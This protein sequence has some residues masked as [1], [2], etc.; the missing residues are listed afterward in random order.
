MLRHWKMFCV[1]L[2]LLPAGWVAYQLAPIRTPIVVSNETTHLTEP[3]AE[4]GLPDYSAALL[5]ELREDVT[6][7]NNGGVQYLQAMWPA[8][9]EPEVWQ[10]ICDELGMDV[11][12]ADGMV[13]PE[14]SELLREEL[15]DWLSAGADPNEEWETAEKANL[16]AEV[17]ASLLS[18]QPWKP[19]DARLVAEYIASH[20]DHYQ[21]LHEAIRKPHFYIP[22][23]SLLVNPDETW[24]A[25][26]LPTVQS[27][28]DATRCLAARANLRIGEGALEMAWEDCQAMY[29]LSDRLESTTL[30]EEL[31]SIATEGVAN[32]ITQN[33]LQDHQLSPELA[34]RVL[35]HFADWPRR[36]GVRQ[37]IDTG[38]RQM[39]I[40]QV[41]AIANIRGEYEPEDLG[42]EFKLSPAAA[43]RVDWNI[44][45]RMA[46]DWYSR[47]VEA[48][49][50]KTW[51]DRNAAIKEWSADLN[52]MAEDLNPMMML[53]SS[54]ASRSGRGRTIG[55]ILV[56]L[57]LPAIEVVFDAEDRANA[58]RQLITIAA[59]LAVYRTEQGEYPESLDALTPELLP[60]RPTDLF[61]QAPFAYRKTVRG[62]LLYSAGPNG[63]D[64]GGSHERNNVLR[65]YNVRTDSDKQDQAIRA[66]LDTPPETP[67]EVGLDDLIPDNA[68]DLALRM[69]PITVPFPM[70]VGAD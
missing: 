63:K 25:M 59:A 9:L 13:S 62:Y 23:P 41:F 16:D 12:E 26:L 4:D 3:L 11:P 45:L 27:V 58:E 35:D 21:L 49:G 40:T 39:F 47:L 37:A 14:S 66:L 17:L 5:A 70:P 29:A 51:T 18:R 43:S 2:V 34:R 22:S 19:A 6:P 7:E 50:E 28:R 30:V 31:V 68:D 48:A 38:E 8:E 55:K 20:D 36:S 61:H 44:V 46:N 54:V 15:A 60:E 32:R 64:D 53:M 1:A 52:E 65:G 42:G 24:I 56:L 69:P 57:M 33:L 67:A 10:A